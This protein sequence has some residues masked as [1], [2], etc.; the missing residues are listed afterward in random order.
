MGD[1]N[2]DNAEFRICQGSLCKIVSSLRRTQL[3][4]RIL[5]GST[6]LVAN[7]VGE[8]VENNDAQQTYRE[9]DKPALMMAVKL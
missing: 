8:S 2:L 1:T 3:H 5:A 7:K 6:Y 9:V 4:N